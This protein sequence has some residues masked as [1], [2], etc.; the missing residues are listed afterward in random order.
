MSTG[1]DPHLMALLRAIRLRAAAPEAAAAG[2]ADTEAALGGRHAPDAEHGGHLPLD[3]QRGTLP[4]AQHRSLPPAPSPLSLPAG[5]SAAEDPALSPPSASAESPEMVVPGRPANADPFAQPIDLVAEANVAAAASAAETD[6][7]APELP[8]AHPAATA[9]VMH[10]LPAAEAPPSA[11]S[12]AASVRGVSGPRPSAPVPTGPLPSG[13]VPS[14]PVPTGPL[15]SGPVRSG[16]VATGPLPG[17]PMP[18]R[19][20]PGTPA[21]GGPAP[22]V[23]P[24][25]A[26][27]P[28]GHPAPGTPPPATTAPGPG[29]VNPGTMV[30]TH[31]AQPP[32]P[33]PPLWLVNPP[34][35]AAP[36]PPASRPAEPGPTPVPW[37][38]PGP[39]APQPPAYRLPPL[40][41]SHGGPISVDPVPGLSAVGR[42]VP[43]QWPEPPNPATLFPG[44]RPVAPAAPPAAA[45]PVSGPDGMDPADDAALREVQ[46]LLG[47]SLSMAGGPDEVAT[48]LRAALVLA[49][50]DL[51][52]LVPGSPLTQREQLA[53]GLTW[54]V[55]HLDRPP[56]LVA[57]CV[58]LG[59]ALAECGVQPQQLQL[60]GAALAEAMRAGMAA[61]GWRQDFDQAWRTTWQHVHEWIGHGAAG[62]GYQPTTWAAR[63]VSHERRRPDLAVI[64][65]RPFLP[66]PFRPGQYAPIELPELPGV[67]RPYSLAGSP[68]RDDVVELHV[69]AKTEAGVSGALVYRAEVGDRVRFGR[70]RGA[71]G[72]PA[73]PGRDLLLVAG[74]TGVAPLKAMLHELAATG[75]RRSAV[76]FWGVRDLDELYDIEEIA[77]IARAC[78]RATVVPVVSEGEAGPYASGLV[79]DAIAAYGEWSGHEVYLAGPPVMLAATSAALQMLGVAPDRIHHDAPEG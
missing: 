54:L 46:R 60:A 63:V 22:A 72:V 8:P 67:W 18:A 1:S 17:N 48:R 73:E 79:T 23:P 77:A 75:D 20:M 71:M 3:Q 58:Q 28:S 49:H 32:A 76:L 69:R 42:P 64:R 47:N 27:P 39:A 7:E 19:A 50:P 61:N 33:H 2:A 43:G 40:P 62:V 16:P 38:R 5:P 30:P 57:G 70:A 36:G 34:A 15:P 26:A 44:V 21:P 74:D 78:H 37:A 29:A 51:V 59:A 53:Q 12:A 24:L 10:P 6:P 41:P 4:E 13:P 52:T 25:P 14:A 11:T 45:L 35:P 9:R 68:R 56:A 31:P 65:F 66:M 55:H